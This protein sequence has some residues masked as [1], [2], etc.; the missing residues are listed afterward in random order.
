MNCRKCGAE[1]PEKS[2]YCNL[3]GVKQEIVRTQR[4]RGNGQG[5]AIKRG[6]S[7][8]AVWTEELQLLEQQRDI[9]Q[10]RRWKGGFPTKTAALAYAAAPPKSEPVEPAEYMPTLKD[11]FELW[12]KSDYLDLSKSKQCAFRIAWR[13]LETLHGRQMASL[14]INELQTCVDDQAETYYPARDMR[15]LL[16]HLFK[17]AVAEG[18][19]RSNLAEFI[20]IPPLDEKEQ[21]PFT[22]EEINKLWQA[23]GSGD[24]V[25]GL[26][27]LMIYS[28]M[29]PGELKRCKTEMIDTGKREIHGCGLKTK[30]RKATPIIYPESISPVVDNLIAT[31]ASSKGFLLGMN[32]DRFYD[33]YHAALGRAGVRDLPPYSCRHTTAT[34]LA[35]A[36]A[37]P[38]VIQEIMRHTKFATT[39][40]YIH[41]DMANAHAAIE[42]LNSTANSNANYDL[43]NRSSEQ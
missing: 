7:W 43:K 42:A 37:A 31:T 18:Q 6:R 9:R 10:V 16:S 41:P 24:R 32:E 1:L 8:T 33:A 12:E 28:G 36:N 39:Q 25:A 17:R 34:A 30:K 22:A 38:S 21:Q 23:C 19:A 15:T 14:T 35:M 29:M 40:R 11:Y 26:V 4:K 13:K 27:L 2:V 20:R 3:C 5:T